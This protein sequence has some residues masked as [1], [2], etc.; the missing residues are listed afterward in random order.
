MLII[1]IPANAQ[2]GDGNGVDDNEV[3]IVFV[4]S[5]W[6]PI[7]PNLNGGA[8]C[9]A[10]MSAMTKTEQR[11]DVVNFTRSYYTWSEGVI[12]ASDSASIT[13]VSDLN[14]AGTNIGVQSGTYADL[15][16][17]ENLQAATTYT[18]DDLADVITALNN[19]D[20]EYAL[21][22]TQDLSLEGTIMV[23]YYAEEFGIAV[24]EDSGELLDALNVAITAIVDSGEY[25]LIYGDWFNGTP[26]LTDDRDANTATSYPVPSNGSTLSSVLNS[27]E[28]RVCAD[29]YYP[30][31]ES[32]D[33][34][35]NPVGFD[36]D[37]GEVVVNEISE[38]Y[39][40]MTDSDGDG[41]IDIDEIAC[42]T[43]PNDENSVPIDSDSD[44][45]CDAID[46]DDDNDGYDNDDDDFPLDSTEW[47]DYDGDGIGSNTDTDDDGDGT[48]DALDA[49]P[50]DSNEY[51]DND[52]DG[53][54]DNTDDDDDNDGWLDY[55]ENECGTSSMNS[56]STPIDTDYDGFCNMVDMD[57]DGDG[58]ADYNDLRPLTL[59]SFD[60]SLYISGDEDS[61]NLK[62]KY[63]VS[64]QAVMQ[65]V[66]IVDLFGD[67]SNSVDTGSEKDSMET[68]LCLSPTPFAEYGE[69]PIWSPTRWVLNVTVDDSIPPISDDSCSWEDRRDLPPSSL[70]D[71]VE[72]EI[73]YTLEISGSG[74][75]IELLIPDF[76]WDSEYWYFNGAFEVDCQGEWECDSFTLYA[77]QGA[78]TLQLFH[79]S[80]DDSSDDSPDS[81]PPTDTSD[82][83]SPDLQIEEEK[84]GEVEE[85]PGF[86]V[87]SAISVLTIVALCG[88]RK[89]RGTL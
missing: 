35:G 37:F 44:D 60:Y 46:S 17:N 6:D 87:L 86:G 78:T 43:D 9:D 72:L 11:D 4:E 27:G 55:L 82:D 21:G 85:I 56:T 42:S 74:T 38:H 24:R 41:W 77:A 2:E 18:Y 54:G 48:P 33:A 23:T 84:P 58:I 51:S 7:I 10:I 25:D 5:A 47:N 31:F 45:F 20:I 64:Y 30:P 88:A 40:S 32:Y 67:N 79:S 26:F 36:I 65:Y 15:Y 66:V 14:T 61:L 16:A 81:D 39:F 75:S 52:G 53:V 50:L 28:L 12:G 13:D 70:L 89:D 80:H 57:D 1:T 63:T 62:M 69:N 83:S 8:M 59:D 71:T 49:F 22:N 73:E 68:T 34:D 76:S 3:E 19:G 29:M